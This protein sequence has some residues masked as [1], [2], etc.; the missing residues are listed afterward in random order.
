[1]VKRRCSSK[2]ERQIQICT[3]NEC[4]DILHY[5]ESE[6]HRRGETF[7]FCFDG[8]TFC[9]QIYK[10]SVNVGRKLS[11]ALFIMRKFLHVRTA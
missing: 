3:L 6:T 9:Q 8:S 1:M 2:N 4:I 7:F 5:I 10:K 11:A